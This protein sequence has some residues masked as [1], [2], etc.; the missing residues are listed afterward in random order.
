MASAFDKAQTDIENLSKKL[1]A[2]GKEQQSIFDRSA[3]TFDNLSKS[4]DEF[5]KKLSNAVDPATY[6]QKAVNK[7]AEEYEKLRSQGLQYQQT[8]REAAANAVFYKA[9]LNDV[10]KQQ[11]ALNGLGRTLTTDEQAKLNTLQQQ[12]AQLSI[13]VKGYAEVAR[14]ARDQ[15]VSAQ[16]ALKAKQ[17]ELA[18]Q[19]AILAIYQTFMSL[20]E[21]YD[22]LL[23]DTAKA[24]GTTKD[25]I[26]GQYSAIQK[27][28]TGLSSNLASNQ[29]ILAAV[30]AAR[31]EYALTTSQLATIGKEAANISRLTGLSA[32]ESVKFQTSLAEIGGTS[33]MAQEA[34]TVVAAKAAEAAGVPMGQVMR[35]VAN[36]SGAVRTIFKGNTAE[37]IKQAAEA[38][39]LGT[40]LDAAAKSAEALLNFDTSIAAEM[41]VSALMGQSLNF[42]ESR[43]LA[44]AGDLIGA[45]KALQLEIQKVGDLDKLNYN[46]RK[47]L[48]EAT[49]KDFGELQKIQTQRKNMLEAERM[50]PEEAKKM[51]KAQ[52]E[53]AAL[54][55]KGPEERKKELEL[56][57][58][59]K[60]AEAEL[61]KLTQAKQEALNNIGKLLQPI[62]ALIMSVQ[63]AFFKFISLITN[64]QNPIGKW[65]A[66][67]TV[68]VLAIVATFYAAKFGIAKVLEFL[69]SAFAKAAQA[70]GEGVGK[71]LSGIASGLT[72]L[73]T[74]MRTISPADL[75]KLGAMLVLLTG[76]AMGLAYA[77]SLLG[78]TSAGQILAFTAALVI[79][80]AALMAAATIFTPPSPLGIGLAIFAA[81]LLATSLAAIAFAKAIQLATPAIEIIGNVITNLATIVGGV[82]VK[83]FD[84]MLGVFQTLPS[85]IDSVASGLLLIANIGFMKM[86]A[87]AAGVMAMSSAIYDLGKNLA[88]FPVNQL[89]SITAQIDMLSNS[90]QGLQYAVESLK[91]LSGV[92]LPTL[93]FGGLAA[94]GALTN[95]S[96]KEETNELRAGLQIIADRLD[97]L[98][99]M[100]ANG[101]IAVNL[102]GTR[103]NHALDTTRSK[104][105]SYGQAT[106]A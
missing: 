71:G 49:G 70:T 85:V 51:R 36:A 58:Q 10:N 65:A 91:E 46:Q 81:G 104:R 100:M 31:K 26:D 21:N 2:V 7:T 76:T 69:G 67:I 84:T 63:T 56:L 66:S 6:L 17:Q 54:S 75:L 90:A 93:E 48:A 57:I 95:A 89:A 55:K 86:S 105:G 102:D 33:V 59:Q 3:K 83:A 34:M 79:L 13:L 62:Y 96:K 42:N 5:G 78:K 97:N 64:I 44:F 35:D 68:G 80:G 101:G 60:T 82:I 41:K 52:E 30:T 37:L 4:A 106:I 24:Q 27:V 28:N 74:A 22:K 18:I 92:Q 88:T 87:A 77:M 16:K 38:R 47:A 12:S 29:E 20:A 15:V 98:T 25:E 23:S 43:R 94:I 1:S 61:Q 73:G 53:L 39:K 32:E 9:Q 99:N 19:T 45:E 72:A 40:S 14:D 50:F 8:Q 11:A 103:V